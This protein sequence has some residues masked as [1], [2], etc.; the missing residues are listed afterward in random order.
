MPWACASRASSS[1]GNRQCSEDTPIPEPSPAY[2]N[3]HLNNNALVSG[4]SASKR[5]PVT[6]VNGTVHTSLG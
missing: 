5:L 3:A 1:S 6:G 2:S 4:V